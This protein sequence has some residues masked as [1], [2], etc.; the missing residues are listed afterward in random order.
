M[1]RALSHATSVS[2]YEVATLC[3]CRSLQIRALKTVMSYTQKRPSK[4]TDK[5]YGDSVR[6]A[7]NGGDAGHAESNGA[8]GTKYVSRPRGTSDAKWRSIP[9]EGV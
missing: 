3:S 2:V 4:R 6:L 7:D 1:H 5:D 8:S 9:S